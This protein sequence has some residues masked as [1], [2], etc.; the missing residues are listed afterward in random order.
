MIQL[1]AVHLHCGAKFLLEDASL[2]VHIGQ[3]VGL[4]GANG[5]GKSSLFKLLLGDLHEDGG[6]VDVPKHWSVAHMAQ[7]VGESQRR[8]VDY[9]IDGDAELRAIEA[10]MASAEGESLGQLYE[11]LEAVDGYT[12]EARAQKLLD[13]LGFK[14]GDSER[15]VDAFSGGWRIRLNLARALM[16]RSDLLLLDEPTNHLD[17][18]ATV[19]LEKWLQHYPGTLLIVSHDRD[20]LDNVVNGIAHLEH[21]KLASYTG[22]YSSFEIQRAERMAQQQQAFEKQQ[23]RKAEVEDFVRRFRAKASKAKQAQSRL[24]ELERMETIAPAHADSPFRFHFPKPEKLPQTLIS[25]TEASI[26]YDQLKPVVSNIEFSVLS[27]SRIGLLGHNGAG[28]S[29]LM[30][31]LAG[32][33][34]LI[35]GEKVDAAHLNVGYFSQHQVETLDFAASPALQLQRISEKATEQEIR[36]FLGAFGFH[37]DRAFEEVEHFSGGEKARVALALLAWQKPNLLLLDEPTNHLDLEVRHAL[38]VA[39]QMYEGAVVIVS[40]DRHLLKS[41]VEQFY[42]VD[43]GQVQPFDGDLGDYEHWLLDSQH[44]TAGANGSGEQNTPSKPNKTDKR[45]QRQRAAELR[46]KLKPISSAIKKREREI[47][48]LQAELDNIEQRLADAE[49]YEAENKQELTELLQKQ[50]KIKEGLNQAEQAWFD[51]NEELEQLASEGSEPE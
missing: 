4:I 50:A 51:L 30:K 33:H 13:G 43:S 24:K 48:S 19:W 16:C 1:H 20:F 41:T 22:N 8:A 14:Q 35:S 45:N 47:E 6:S 28:K 39:L 23:Q 11:K 7:E 44:S 17:L 5:S 29:T 34:A 10:Q 3:K 46:Q 9:I 42:L 49:L 21:K 2:T 40:H 32:A 25:L 26:G 36:G 37:G 15:S 27:S 38:T 18:D 12:V 31:T